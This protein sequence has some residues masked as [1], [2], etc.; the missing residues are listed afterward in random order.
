MV[1]VARSLAQRHIAP[2]AEPFALPESLD[3]VLDDIWTRWVRGSV[4]RRSAF[5]T[6][7]VAS[8]SLDGKPDQRVMVLRK[9]HRPTGLLRF[10]TDVRSSKVAALAKNAEVSVI[11]YDAG[12]KIQVRAGGTVQVIQ[13]GA[14]ANTAWA[15]TSPSGR[16]SYMTLL[17]PGS[18]SDHPTSGL[19]DGP[20]EAPSLEASEAA[21]A[22]FS[23]VQVTLT[24]LEW[25]YLASSGH[26]RAAFDCVEGQWVGTWL[27]P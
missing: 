3:A 5:H 22:N 18:R 7:S 23:I 4:D 24:R 26:R 1:T 19:G 15:A 20:Q 16:R 27:I 8:V 10:H 17:P 13:S 6:P 2:M 14:E 9:V 21:R 11:G 25:L 12:A